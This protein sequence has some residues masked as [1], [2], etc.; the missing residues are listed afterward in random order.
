MES[1]RIKNFRSLKD[2]GDIKIKPL[3]ILVG[4][5]SAGKSSFLR[6]F[7]MFRQ[8]IEERTKSPILLYRRNGVDFGTYKD[9]KSIYSNSDE[10]I[11]FL[12][13][14]KKLNIRKGLE[15][16]LL[17]SSQKQEVD[18]YFSIRISSKSNIPILSSVKIE[19]KDNEIE[20]FF[21]NEDRI[22]LECIVING[23]KY[24]NKFYSYSGSSFLPEFFVSTK[25]NEFLSRIIEDKLKNLIKSKSRK[26][27]N[28]STFRKLIETVFIINSKEDIFNLIE[29]NKDMKTWAKNVKNLGIDSKYYEDLYQNIILYNLGNIISSINLE[30]KQI[31]RNIK[32]IAPVR[33]TA[34]RYYRIQDLSV[35]E[36]DPYGQNLPMFLGSLSPSL[37]SKFQ[38]W[39][40][41]NFGFK[42]IIKTSDG[43]YSIR[44][45]YDNSEE[46]NISDMGFGYSQILPII[47]QIWHSSQVSDSKLTY[48]FPDNSLKIFVIE[49]P[50]L[51]LHPEFQAK[52]LDCIVNVLEK[53]DD[54]SKIKFI[55]ET[56]SQTIIN[57]AGQSIF[58]KV[59]SK[60]DVNIVIF[61]KENSAKET[62]VRVANFDEDGLLENWPIGFFKP[63]SIN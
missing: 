27:I 20:L 45:S 46:I 42:V 38:K 41:D 57:R 21:K 56:H 51:H 15:Y 2:T 29:N 58:K 23:K 17:F 31:F 28:D 13:N 1:I 52:F 63:S 26:G 19:L 44:I 54:K 9:I 37:M 47:T 10:E 53:L 14:L 39:T 59:I 49:Q 8:T 25:D 50:E 4:K 55:I 40:S 60:D 61:E 18:I 11:E 33:A 34:E 48:G 36:V 16:P 62:F 35:E 5:N 24:E 43:H 3:T 12:F 7:P 32:Y 22:I 30:L 6:T